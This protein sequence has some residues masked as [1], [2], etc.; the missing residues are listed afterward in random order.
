MSITWQDGRKAVRG[1]TA[2]RPI[3]AKTE[4]GREVVRGI[5]G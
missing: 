4:G 2:V 1:I 3:L 5:T